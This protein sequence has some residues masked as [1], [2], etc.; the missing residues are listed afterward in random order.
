MCHS[1]DFS[2]WAFVV[3]VVAVEEGEVKVV[4]VFCLFLFWLAIIG[5]Y[6]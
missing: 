6:G 2:L 4:V 1:P 3:V 5:N